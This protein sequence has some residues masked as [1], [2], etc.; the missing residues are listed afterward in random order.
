LNGRYWRHSGHWP[1]LA[2]IASVA[3][4]PERTSSPNDSGQHRRLHEAHRQ[5]PAMALGIADHVSSLGELIDAALAQVPPELGRRHKK[6]DLTV[7]DGG[8]I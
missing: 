1:T 5:T 6:P 7:I 8:K 3:I 4:D 2:L